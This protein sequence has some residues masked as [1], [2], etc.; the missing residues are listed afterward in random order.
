MAPNSNDSSERQ[1]QV[2]RVA[3]PMIARRTGDDMQDKQKMLRE[4]K[5]KQKPVNHRE[6]LNDNSR[7]VQLLSP[8]CSEQIQMGVAPIPA[9]KNRSPRVVRFDLNEDI[10]LKKGRQRKKLRYNLKRRPT[11][12][13]H[14]RAISLKS[15]FEAGNRN[16]GN[17]TTENLNLYEKIGPAEQYLKDKQ[18]VDSNRRKDAVAVG[19]EIAGFEDFD[20]AS[21]VL[22]DFTVNNYTKNPRHSE[23]SKYR[24]AS[25]PNEQTNATVTT[26]KETKSGRECNLEDL[27]AQKNSS[28][29][30]DEIEK[31]HYQPLE[32]GADVQNVGIKHS[33][34]GKPSSNGPFE[35]VDKEIR[36]VQVET[37]VW[38]Y[39]KN[40]HDL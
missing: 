11:P 7:D 9:A 5:L 27:S 39:G 20:D 15:A 37:P 4:I 28:F 35:N 10:Q 2:P 3:T 16:K 30:H 34:R 36:E 24:F 21:D 17:I 1:G 29:D 13:S 26:A 38:D 22:F 14:P 25:L 6:K 12:A 23:E 31:E 8:G 19:D 32:N 18:K 33:E 40:W